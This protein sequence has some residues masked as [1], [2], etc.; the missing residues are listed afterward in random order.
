MKEEAIQCPEC[1][2]RMSR[3]CLTSV[4][5]VHWTPFPSDLKDLKK[6]GIRLVKPHRV[7]G[8]SCSDCGLISL[9]VQKTHA[10]CGG[11]ASF[12]RSLFSSSGG[13]CGPKLEH[14]QR[15]EPVEMRR[16]VRRAMIGVVVL[17]MLVY[18]C[19]IV[20]MGVVLS[21]TLLFAFM[22][23]VVVVWV[24]LAFGFR[25]WLRALARKD[26]GGK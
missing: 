13:R 2:G 3:G 5:R 4:V 19:L 12:V 18:G 14:E 9:R 16:N 11:L 8:W 7:L 21:N 1:G 24:S 6:F 15:G 17:M 26:S 22:C 25:R 10:R 20:L 23:A